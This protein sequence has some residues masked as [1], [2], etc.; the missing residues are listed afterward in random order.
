[1]STPS[2]I[3]SRACRRTLARR[4]RPPQITSASIRMA[5]SFANHHR[6][7]PAIHGVHRTS[8][9]PSGVRTRGARIGH[10]R[11]KVVRRHLS[12]DRAT[13]AVRQCAEARSR[14]SA[15]HCRQRR[16]RD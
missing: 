13:T 11:T 16:A 14:S 10:R 9:N 4:S 2:T 8:P 1:V 7:R 6:A 5:R 12:I 15:A 3:T